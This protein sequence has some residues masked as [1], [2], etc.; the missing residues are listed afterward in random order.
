MSEAIFSAHLKAIYYKTNQETLPP[1]AH[2]QN[3]CHDH[4][5]PT[6]YQHAVAA[7]WQS[8]SGARDMKDHPHRAFPSV[9]D[10]RKKKNTKVTVKTAHYR[11]LQTE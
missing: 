5:C 1:T 7:T 10:E 8:L 2:R 9:S 6:S 3:F 11:V 4:N